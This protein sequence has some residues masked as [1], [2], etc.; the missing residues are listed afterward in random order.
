MIETHAGA[1]EVADFCAVLEVSQ[2][3]Y[4]AWRKREPSFHERQDALLSKGIRAIFAESR[5]TYGAQ[6]ICHALR[7]KGIYSSVKRIARL[8]RTAGLASVRVKKRRIGLTKAARNAFIVPNL[9]AQNF[10]TEKANEKWVT[11]TTYIPTKAGWL[12]LVTVLD[13]YSRM[14]VGWAMGEQHDAKL[15][16]AALVMAIQRQKPAEGL[17]LHS[18]KGT[19]FANVIYAQTAESAKMQRSMSSTGNCYD[20]AVAESFFATLKL[21][22]VQEQLYASHVEAR[23]ALFD[24]IE[25]FYNRQRLHSSLGFL[26]PCRFAA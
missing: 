22:T 9:L 14:I 16:K 2:S 18:D 12:Y 23:A 10:S 11:D 13:L 7:E 3:G 6:R 20:N 26:S 15:A 25:V 4:Y 8:M 5:Q 24:Y 19:E 21:E 17:I 1:I